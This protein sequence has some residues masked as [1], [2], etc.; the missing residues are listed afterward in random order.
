MLRLNQAL[1]V[2]MP[3]FG[4]SFVEGIVGSPHLVNP[5]LASFDA[6]QDISHLL[7]SGL[8]RPDVDGVLVP[9]LAQKYLI[10]P[11][12]KE[13][14]FTLFEKATFHDGTPITSDDIEFTIKKVLDP[15]LKSPHR[16]QWE[17]VTIEKISEK[18]IK[19]TLKQPYA[20]FLE[21]TTLGILPKHIWSDLNAEQFSVSPANTEP[22]VGSGPY[23]LTS[24]KKESD[25]S[26]YQ[27][28]LSAFKKYAPGSAH[29]QNLYL[30]FFPSEEKALAAY[31][32]KQID[33]LTT[34]SPNNA[35]FLNS[36][37]SQIIQ[38]P[39]PRIFGVFLNQNQSP[40]F[41]FPE[42]RKALNDSI[43]RE[44]IVNE[45]L[46]GYGSISQSPLPA[47]FFPI[48]KQSS[49]T[50][51]TIAQAHVL[52]EKNGWKKN[53]DGIYEKTAPKAK[54]P[55]LLS[56]TL[57][58]TN[59]ADLIKTAQLLKEDW[60][61]FG[62][63][64]DIKIFEQGDLNQNVLQPR[65]YEAF[66]FGEVIGRDL[67]LFAFWH[68]S[69]RNH[70]GLNIALY[71]NSKADDYLEDSR[72]ATSTSAQ[73]EMLLK[74]QSEVSKDNPA[75][76]LY[77]PDFIYITPQKIKSIEL[78]SIATPSERFTSI[79]DWYIETEKVWDPELFTFFNKDKE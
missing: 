29:I 45:V 46:K 8:M 7:Y 17:G 48:S 66:L 79:R 63:K 47:T 31:N 60:E 15:T 30:N 44:K 42:V 72:A 58:T 67:D 22:R 18:Q 34:L 71:T 20:A 6:D 23:Q 16:A 69:Q 68:S 73:R 54:E 10:S 39:L 3:S 43:D 40:I 33:S 2:E 41:V 74:F 50:A 75:L 9:D 65:K 78:N 26:I 62:I 13:Y 4:G 11:D 24:T 61:S 25:G 53:T 36:Q 56:F 57:S 32:A 64:V 1:L 59:A 35:A 14:E 12:G 70:P 52:L 38:S 37:T 51:E 49:T 27:Y 28:S 55:T 19:F 76:F 21:S 5:I 77:S